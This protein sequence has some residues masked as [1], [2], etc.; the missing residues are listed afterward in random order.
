M[1]ILHLLGTNFRNF[2]LYAFRGSNDNSTYPAYNNIVILITYSRVLETR[3]R[4][5]LCISSVPTHTSRT[6]YALSFDH[7]SGWVFS[8]VGFDVAAFH[9]YTYTN[10]ILFDRNEF[11]CLGKKIKY[12]SK[13]ERVKSL[14]ETVIHV[15]CT[16][17]IIMYVQFCGGRTR[18]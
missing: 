2:R 7:A 17:H 18:V 15:L 16:V 8:P 1:Y 11:R 13:H 3:A 9:A 5:N 14:P 6:A 12:N 10:N 4:C